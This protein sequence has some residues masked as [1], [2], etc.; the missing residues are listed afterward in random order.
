MVVWVDVEA[1]EVG[2]ARRRA[3]SLSL[4]VAFATSE[5]GHVE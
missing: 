3:Q 5:R 2:A 4:P 1:V